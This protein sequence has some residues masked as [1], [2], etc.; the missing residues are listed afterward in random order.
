MRATEEPSIESLEAALE[1]ARR[2]GLPESNGH[3]LKTTEM[4]LLLQQRKMRGCTYCL[5]YTLENAVTT[6]DPDGDDLGMCCLNDGDPIFVEDFDSVGNVGEVPVVRL[7]LKPE[8]AELLKIS[9]DGVIIDGK[10]RAIPEDSEKCWERSF[11]SC[12]E[13]NVDIYAVVADRGLTAGADKLLKNKWVYEPLNADEHG[14]FSIRAGPYLKKDGSNLGK[15]AV[16]EEFAVADELERPEGDAGESVTYLKLA[17]PSRNGWVFDK[18]PGVGLMCHRVC[19]CMYMSPDR[20]EPDARARGK[21]ECHTICRRKF[22]GIK[23]PTSDKCE[24]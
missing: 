17:D 13:A 5:T 16:H 14:P 3:L 7:T 4:L 1:E 10:W 23:K 6:T 9:S 8:L 24:N 21:P 15:L 18:R 2:A 22:H 11:I 12:K 19:T 20:C